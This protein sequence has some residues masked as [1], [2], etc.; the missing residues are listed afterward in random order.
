MTRSSICSGAE[1]DQFALV[2]EEINLLS[3]YGGDQFAGCIPP[4]HKNMSFHNF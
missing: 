4:M 3:S 2:M 1:H